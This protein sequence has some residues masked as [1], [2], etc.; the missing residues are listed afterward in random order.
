LGRKE[1]GNSMKNRL[2]GNYFIG[3]PL[4]AVVFAEVLLI[5]LDL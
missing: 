4:P 2:P 5:S 3:Q 1:K